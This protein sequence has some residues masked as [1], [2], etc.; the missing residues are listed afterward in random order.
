MAHDML[1]LEAA[2][3]TSALFC[4]SCHGRHEGLSRRVRNCSHEMSSNHGEIMLPIPVKPAVQLVVQIC[5]SDAHQPQAV[6]GQQ[7]LSPRVIDP[8]L[9]TA[10]HPRD[11]QPVWLVGMGNGFVVLPFSILNN[12]ARLRLVSINGQGTATTVHADITA[13][14]LEVM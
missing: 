8:S 9:F 5:G 1:G 2:L 4:G 10:M 12:Q 6:G 14:P 11:R 3:K 13:Q 7:L